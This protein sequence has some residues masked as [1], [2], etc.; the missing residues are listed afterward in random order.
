M[1]LCALKRLFRI[2]LLKQKILLV[3]ALCSLAINLSYIA[4][5]INDPWIYMWNFG[6]LDMAHCLLHG[7][8][9]FVH[10]SLFDWDA[11]K[12]SP[13][14][15]FSDYVTGFEPAFPPIY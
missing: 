1:L 15:S 4:F 2:W 3:I 13:G 9:P 11:Y 14:G 5:H 12:A 10:G 7:A 8:L 6:Q